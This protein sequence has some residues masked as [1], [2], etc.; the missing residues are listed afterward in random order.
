[1]YDKESL[2]EIETAQGALF[3]SSLFSVIN[4]TSSIGATCM[5]TTITPSPL[6]RPST[7]GGLETGIS[8]TPIS[9]TALEGSA[10]PVRGVVELVFVT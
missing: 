6:I 7:D 10:G 8:K 9:A 1:M 5:A 2:I 4:L 3:A